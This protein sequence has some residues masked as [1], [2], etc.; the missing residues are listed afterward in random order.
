MIIR[1]ALLSLIA[2]GLAGFGTIVWM[3]APH[4][5]TA[6]AATA[7]VTKLKV[8]VAARGLRPGSLMKADDIT[9]REVDEDKLPNGFIADETNARRTLT[10]APS[11]RNADDAGAARNGANASPYRL[12]TSQ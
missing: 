3:V 1:I 4:G 5:D 11:T 9:M 2:C 12:R 8:L 7:P 6:I 10:G